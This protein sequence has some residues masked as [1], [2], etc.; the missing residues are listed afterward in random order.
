MRRAMTLLELLVGLVIFSFAILPILSFGTTTTRTTYITGKHL[1]AGQIAASLLDRLLALPYDEALAEAERLRGLGT[2]K[3]LED[4][5]LVS[6][7]DHQGLVN[8]R[9]VL[10]EDLGKTFRFFEFKVGIDK[11]PT[12]GAADRMFLL[13]VLVSWR[14]E[15]GDETSRTALIL[16]GVKFN[17]LR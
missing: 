5:W 3:V 13:T 4:P 8:G 14:V 1:M 2:T 10:E 12:P 9:R 15:E 7:L 17:D 11:D 16:Q 6:L